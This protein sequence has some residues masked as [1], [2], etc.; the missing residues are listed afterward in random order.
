MLITAIWLG[1]YGHFLTFGEMLMTLFALFK[2]IISCRQKK[3]VTCSQLSITSNR[4]PITSNRLPV[5]SYHL[6]ITSY[7]L[8]QLPI[9]SNRLPITS[10]QLPVTSYF[11]PI[12]GGGGGVSRPKGQPYGKFAEK[13]MAFLS[14]FILKFTSFFNCLRS[15]S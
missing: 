4:L 3:G 2:L 11:L 6:P 5:T 8:Y 7:H 14:F 9:A 13:A 15:V 10:N 12:R 1:H